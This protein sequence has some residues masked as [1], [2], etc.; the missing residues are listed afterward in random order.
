MA[1]YT[2]FDSL[3]DQRLFISIVRP[4]GVGLS[5]VGI[6]TK[7]KVLKHGPLKYKGKADTGT[8]QQ[9]NINHKF[10]NSH[11]IENPFIFDIP[12]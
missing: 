12:L 1:R 5:Y 11:K 7:L 3:D 10:L 9:K 6:T 8:P 2:G 4:P